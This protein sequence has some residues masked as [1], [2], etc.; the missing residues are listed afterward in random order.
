M[1]IRKTPIKQRSNNCYNRKVAK[2]TKW[3]NKLTEY[4]SNPKGN[5]L[6]NPNTKQEPKRK[7]LKD[8]SYYIEKIKKPKSNKT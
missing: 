8:L 7:E 3:H 1:A 4:R 6:I 5:N 2:I